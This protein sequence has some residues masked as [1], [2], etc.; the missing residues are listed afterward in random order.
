M[1]PIIVGIYKI[2]KLDTNEWYVGK[3]KQI[4][5]RWEQH[6]KKYTYAEG[7]TYSVLEECEFELLN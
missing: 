3:S 5:A 2:E 4:H 1:K 6:S 7:W